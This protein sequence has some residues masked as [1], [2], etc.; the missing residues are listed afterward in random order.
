M[1]SRT[2]GRSDLALGGW[3][4]F[5]EHPLGVGTGGFGDAWSTLNRREGLSD[6]REGARTAAHSAW[7]RVLAENGIPGI[8]ALFGFVFSFAVIGWRRRSS[9]AFPLG[10]L[11]TFTLAVAFLAHEFQGK[12]LWFLVAGA[13]TLLRRIPADVERRAAPLP[14][15][16]PEGPRAARG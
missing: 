6:F 11:V 4:I 15:T 1:S 2:S 3:Y 7:I 10:L 14:L 9:G 8:L 13:M 16:V 5:Q 12:G